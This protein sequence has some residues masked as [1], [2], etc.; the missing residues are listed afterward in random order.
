MSPNPYLARR[1]RI[2]LG[3]IE[4]FVNSSRGQDIESALGEA[5][6]SLHG[7][8]VVE[9]A[10]EL[11][12]LSQERSP[13]GKPFGRNR[14]R[15][16]AQPGGAASVFASVGCAFGFGSVRNGVNGACGSPR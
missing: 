14:L 5:V 2:F 10:P 9:R 11:I 1:P 8:V 13:A 3:Q 4:C 7:L 12:E 6:H 16:E 15:I